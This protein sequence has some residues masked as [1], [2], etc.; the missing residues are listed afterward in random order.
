MPEPKCCKFFLYIYVKFSKVSDKKAQEFRHINIYSIVNLTSAAFIAPIPKIIVIKVI[1]VAILQLES[2]RYQQRHNLL[3]YMTYICSILSLQCIIGRFSTVAIFGCFETGR[4]FV[5]VFWKQ[6][7]TRVGVVFCL[8][9]CVND[10]LIDFLR[11]LK[12]SDRL[13]G[14]ENSTFRRPLGLLEENF[15]RPESKLRRPRSPGAR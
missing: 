5:A 10:F 13:D 3:A 6:N 15:S 8:I 12:S 7:R 1:K 9:Y 4:D 2:V 11:R 14:N